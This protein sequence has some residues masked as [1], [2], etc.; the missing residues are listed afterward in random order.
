MILLNRILLQKGGHIVSLFAYILDIISVILISS[1]LSET[2]IEEI[3]V[4]STAIILLLIIALRLISLLALKNWAYSLFYKH[5][6][7]E[8][9]NLIY[10]TLNKIRK[11]KNHNIGT[12][13]EKILFSSEISII[14]F[15][16]PISLLAGEIIVLSI[17]TYYILLIV[18]VTEF[19]MHAAVIFMIIF[20]IYIYLIKLVSRLGKKQIKFQE[21]KIS[22]I[23]NIL[24]MAQTLALNKAS[25]YAVQ[26]HSD[27]EYHCN[28]TTVSLMIINQLTSLLIEFMMLMIGVLVLISA[29]DFAQLIALTPLAARI[30]P[31]ISKV[32]AY[33]SQLAFGIQAVRNI[34]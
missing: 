29:K 21:E 25:S 20:S 31:S 8:N 26:V 3:S 16:V 15:D 4:I 14:N 18:D 19:I 10:S 5:K 2:P 7:L 33:F 12:T 30:A 17:S 32:A 27:N 23:S 28:R 1:I 22:W 6:S 13:R 9:Q 24:N 34:A 11:N